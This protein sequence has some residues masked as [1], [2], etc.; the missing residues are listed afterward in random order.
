MCAAPPI[1]PAAKPACDPNAPL[2]SHARRESRPCRERPVVTAGPP[3]GNRPAPACRQNV[4]RRPGRATAP[5]IPPPNLSP[6]RRRGHRGDASGA[7]PRRHRPVAIGDPAAMRRVMHPDIAGKGRTQVEGANR[8]RSTTM[9]SWPQSSDHHPQSGPKSA[10]FDKRPEADRIAGLEIEPD[11]DREDN[12]ADIP[13]PATSRTRP[14]SCSTGTQTTWAS[15]GRIE[16]VVSAG[17]DHA[18]AL[19]RRLEGSRPA[20]HRAADA[21]TARH[22]VGLLGEEGVT[23]L[24]R[25]LQLLC[26]QRKQLG[27]RHQRHNAGVPVLGLER[28]GQCVALERSDAPDRG[29]TDPPRRFRADK[30]TPLAPG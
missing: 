30:S 11:R 2:R 13:A 28:A 21:C 27:K 5:C 14:G 18:V 17:L 4:V 20:S 3:R 6:A 19:R 1:R 24:L 25:P 10:S 9:S 12:T 8:P 15:D 22:Y 26:H 16:I 23:E 29:P 7:E